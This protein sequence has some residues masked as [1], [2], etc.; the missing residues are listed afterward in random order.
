M[1]RILQ[2]SAVTLVIGLSTLSGAQA[3]F[4]HG[5]G[6]FGGFAHEEHFDRGD[7]H[8]DFRDDRRFDDHRDFRDDQRDFREFRGF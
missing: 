7:D 5:G 2:I 8:R 6:G 1:N 3:A 4:R